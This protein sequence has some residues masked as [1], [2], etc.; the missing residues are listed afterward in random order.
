MS[1]SVPPKSPAAAA[2]PK[3][4]SSPLFRVILLLGLAAGGAWAF[5]ETRLHLST[6]KT[7]DAYII[8]HIHQVAAGVPGTLLE[9]LVDDNE[10][11]KNGQVLARVDPQEFEIMEKKAQA[12]QELAAADALHAKAQA[13]QARSA[14]AQADSMIA[15]AAASVEQSKAQL[16]FAKSNLDR[17]ESLGKSGVRAISQ[18]DLEGTRNEYAAAQANLNA[19]NARLES[20][21][22]GKEASESAVKAAEAGIASAEASINS[23]A[24]AIEEARRQQKLAVIT[25]PADGRIG[26]KNAET[27]N[28]VQTGQDLF[29]VVG[30]DLWVVGNFKETQLEKMRI[31]QPVDIALDALGGR[32]FTGKIDSFS[33]STGAQFALLPP[34][35]ATG[36][37]TKVVQR[38]PVKIRFDADSVKGFETALRPGLSTVI[39]VAVK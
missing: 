20:A 1:E 19:N 23:S 11:V 16:A 10:T 21:K 9:V 37:F 2:A 13:A 39:R 8:G 22:S 5:Q 32:H 33:P 34:D 29:A 30:D 31:G 12:A 3:K 36:N 17:D 28:R 18:S 14:L 25:A 7:D 27:G 24:A 35:N 15:A 6:E 4:K 26:N 38:V